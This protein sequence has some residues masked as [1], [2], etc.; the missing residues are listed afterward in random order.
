MIF[1]SADHSEPYSTAVCPEFTPLV[2][3][4]TILFYSTILP[5]FERTVHGIEIYRMDYQIARDTMLVFTFP[6]SRPPSMTPRGRF[7][8]I[9]DRFANG[10]ETNRRVGWIRLFTRSLYRDASKQ[11]F[12]RRCVFLRPKINSPVVYYACCVSTL[13]VS[14]EGKLLGISLGFVKDFYRYIYMYVWTG[15]LIS[16]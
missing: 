15:Q 9:F 8:R 5:L 1:D 3:L 14:H 12:I 10:F 4:R 16:F 2:W 6:S 11:R 13:F 7:T